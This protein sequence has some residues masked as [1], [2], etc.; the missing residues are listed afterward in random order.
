VTDWA[1]DNFVLSHWLLRVVVPTL[2]CLCAI[3]PGRV[4]M[5]VTREEDSTRQVIV[6]MAARIPSAFYCD[7]QKN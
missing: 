7:T 1:L 5:A 4:N 3:N 6:R 2:W